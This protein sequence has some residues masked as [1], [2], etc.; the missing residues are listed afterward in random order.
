[1]RVRLKV[2]F[3]FHFFNGYESEKYIYANTI[4]FEGDR[5][6]VDAFGTYIEIKD[7]IRIE[8]VTFL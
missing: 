7:L 3:K 6:I 4:L 8:T 1:M 5:A 2:F